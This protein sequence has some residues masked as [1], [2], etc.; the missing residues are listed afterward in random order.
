[1]RMRDIPAPLR[2]KLNTGA[3]ETRT[4]AEWLV[5]DIRV[6]A[7]SVVPLLPKAVAGEFVA[8]AD[9]L[10]SL[11]V[12]QRSK[13]M[14]AALHRALS[15]CDNSN[16]VFERFATHRADM[17]RTWAGYS[18]M[19][20][21]KLKL[22]ARLK[23]GRRFAADPHMAVRECAWDSIRP[24]LVAELDRAIEL[25]EK[26]VRDPDAGVRR[27]AIEATR[28]RG[29]WCSHF[30]ALK[31]DPSPALPLLEAVRND[32]SRYV[33]RSCANWLNDASKTRPDWV[34]QVTTR[35]LKESPTRQTQWLVNH[36]RRTMRKKG[37]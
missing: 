19:A 36:A 21:G 1:M 23:I 10:A 13:G 33:T 27:C 14:G 37:T 25:L 17:V 18:V 12:T 31:K 6:L 8:A 3:E 9:E 30:E 34:T 15:G 4:L 20:D 5:I 29:V 11:G 28:P 32:A 24:A 22:P 26:W 16:T 7:R 35:W 2:E